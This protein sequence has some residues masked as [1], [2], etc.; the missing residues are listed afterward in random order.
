MCVCVYVVDHPERVS[1]SS[2]IPRTSIYNRIL[3]HQVLT[4][5][6]VSSEARTMHVV[7]ARRD[8]PLSDEGVVRCWYGRSGIDLLAIFSLVSV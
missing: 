2:K 5:P 7:R 1:S 3:T 6:R 8:T 4:H